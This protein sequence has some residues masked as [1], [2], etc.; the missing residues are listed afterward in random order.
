MLPVVVDLET[1]GVDHNVHAILEIACVFLANH[2]QLSLNDEFFHEHVKPFEGALKDPQAMALNKIPIDHPFRF[3]KTEKETLEKLSEKLNSLLKKNNCHRCI[4]IG[5]NAHFDLGFINKS[6]ERVGLKS[7]FHR[8]CVLDT[9]SLS[10]VMLGETV[11][12]KALRRAKIG[13]DPS[14]AHSALY[15]AT[16]TAKLFCSLANRASSVK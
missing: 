3:E 15:D 10:A 16:Q 12:A 13:F 1:S 4:L 11:L 5:H 14:Q 7:P 6:Y 9:V 2:D 8:F